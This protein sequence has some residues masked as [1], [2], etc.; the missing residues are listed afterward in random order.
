M[1]LVAA[2]SAG[3]LHVLPSEHPFPPWHCG[4][5]ECGPL[6]LRAGLL[7]TLNRCGGCTLFQGVLKL[8]QDEWGETWTPWTLLWSWRTWTKPF[9]IFIP[10]FCLCRPPSL[11]RPGESLHRWGGETQQEVG[12]PPERLA[13]VGPA[14]IP[15]RG[16][17]H[18]KKGSEPLAQLPLR[19]PCAS[20]RC[21]DFCLNVFCSH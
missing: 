11:W 9:W 12:H 16:Q 8:S 14:S 17:P 1:K 20:P 10:W 18:L 21:Q 7:K 19:G 13:T 4:S 15:L 5:G 6:L 3:L 2:A